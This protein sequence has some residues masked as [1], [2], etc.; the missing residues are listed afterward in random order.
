MTFYVLNGSP[1]K[2]HNT[3]KI[4]E[5]AMGG[6]RSILPDAEI[7][8]IHVYDY[9]YSGC[10][11]CYGCK[12][13]NGKYYGRCAKQDSITGL[14]ERISKGDG[15]LIG[16]PVFFH[17]IPGQ[18]RSFLERLLY[19]YLVYGQEYTSIAPRRFPVAFLYTM[20]ATKEKMKQMN[21]PIKL[22]AM[23]E[24]AG[25]V[26]SRPEIFHCFDT[27]QFDNYQLYKA[28]R[29]SENEKLQVKKEQF[30]KDCQRAVELGKRMAQKSICQNPIASESPGRI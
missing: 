29:F 19:P 2:N 28:D 25:T 15:L 10:V 8:M 4:L 11:S 18:L 22:S 20:N 13:V 24:Y 17:D 3:A 23:E 26:F 21:Y 14:L 27:C 7:E 9:S 16:S 6:I 30:P 5:S 12:R 1:R